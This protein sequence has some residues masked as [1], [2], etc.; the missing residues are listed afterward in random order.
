[1]SASGWF[2]LVDGGITVTAQVRFYLDGAEVILPAD[3]SLHITTAGRHIRATVERDGETIPLGEAL[4]L[5]AML[6]TSSRPEL[7]RQIGEQ[8]ENVMPLFGAGSKSAYN[9]W[10]AETPCAGNARRLLTSPTVGGP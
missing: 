6:M 10:I 2:C 1:M 5:A 4:A 7:R 9:G 8:K 3:W